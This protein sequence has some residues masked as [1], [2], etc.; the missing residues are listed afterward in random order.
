MAVM[1]PDQVIARGQ[2]AFQQIMGNFNAQLAAMTGGNGVNVNSPL[3]L[4]M[5]TPTGNTPSIFGNARP[6]PAAVE[7]PLG[8][9]TDEQMEAMRAAIKARK[10][11]IAIEF[12]F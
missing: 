7:T 10:E 6:F 4:N 11:Q 3:A 1:T 5:Q 8:E 9:E 2:E 12:K